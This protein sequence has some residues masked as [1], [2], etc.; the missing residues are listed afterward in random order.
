MLLEYKDTD[1]IPE[2]VNVLWRKYPVRP[3]HAE[4]IRCFNCNAY[5]H[6]AIK[7]A[8]KQP[9]C[10]KCAGEHKFSECQN[11]FIKCINCKGNHAATSRECPKY[12]EV[13][14]TLTIVNS[15]RLSYKEALL[16]IRSRPTIIENT[17]EKQGTTESQ[18]ATNSQNNNDALK[19]KAS[20]IPIEK[21][22][23]TQEQMTVSNTVEE[24]DIQ[25]ISSC[26]QNPK[27]AIKSDENMNMSSFLTFIVKFMCLT[28]KCNDIKTLGDEVLKLAT[29]CFGQ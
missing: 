11:T 17:T 19:E 8:K 2:Y 15:E 3:Y 18:N 22:T 26:E 12:I 25:E 24:N 7:C 27:K 1:K 10:S 13:K 4:P 5:G 14:E 21:Q 16:K 28:K 9:K 6:T 29:D 23:N 20:E